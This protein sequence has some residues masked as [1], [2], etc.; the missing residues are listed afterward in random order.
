MRIVHNEPYAVVVGGAAV[1]VKA[2]SRAPARLQTSNPGTIT[3]T[4]GGVGRNIAEGLARLGS[5]VH[6][7]AAIG[8]DPAGDALLE[9]TARAGVDVAHVVRSPHATGSYLAVLDSDGELVA[10]VSD[11][12][13]TD[14]L[15]V[16]QIAGARDLIAGAA[17][18]VLDGNLPAA[19]VVW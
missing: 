4:A 8:S 6:L 19:V 10:G 18:V 1:D 11:F 13:A 3:R 16:A 15:T 14:S 9:E 2:R 5:R 12:A 7:V 17:V